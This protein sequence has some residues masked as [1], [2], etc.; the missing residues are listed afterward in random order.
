[1]STAR[2][3]VSY[4]DLIEEFVLNLHPHLMRAWNE[5]YPVNVRAMLAQAGLESGW[6][7]SF[8]AREAY[9]YWGVKA[10]RRWEGDVLE[11][12]TVEFGPKGYFRKTA[13]WR[14]YGSP[15]EAIRDYVR[16]ING[17]SWYADA[18]D[19]AEPPRGDGDPIGWFKA[20]LPNPKRNEPG[21]ATDPDYFAKLKGALAN[22]DPALKEAGL[23]PFGASA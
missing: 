11:L 21:W 16:I 23:Y 18:L 15:Y 17:L 13:R 1:M 5:G 12:P 9:N 4:H 2:S 6:G 7:R 19:H 8:L 3:S 20:L 10:G 14:K 22:V